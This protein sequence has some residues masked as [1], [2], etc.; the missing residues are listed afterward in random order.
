MENIEKNKYYIWLSSIEKISTRE[1]IRLLDKYKNPQILF[2]KS[3][4][5]LEE[6][7]TDDYDNSSKIIKE[8]TNT[9][10]R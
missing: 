9:Y 8:L 1:K 5:E 2:D 7:L 6:E 3:K 10:T 4:K